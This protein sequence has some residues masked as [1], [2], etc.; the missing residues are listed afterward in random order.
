MYEE[1]MR[2]LDTGS[3]NTLHDCPDCG[4]HKLSVTKRD[5]KLLYHCW[6][7]SCGIRGTIEL[8]GREAFE[9]HTPDVK[10]E[11][12]YKGPINFLH[13]DEADIISTRFRLSA[14][15]VATY[16]RKNRDRYVLPIYT[17]DGMLRGYCLRWP[18]AGTELIQDVNYG[19]LKSAL[20]GEHTERGPLQS[21][22]KSTLGIARAVVLVEDQISAM[23]LAQDA[24]VDAVALLGVSLNAEK[25]AD[26]QRRGNNVVIALDADATRTAFEHARTWGAAF[27]SCRVT[28][29]TKDV[30][31][32]TPE[33]LHDAFF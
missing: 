31:D 30:K 1:Y 17:R 29:L 9:S 25:V 13:P 32:M 20:Y 2:S 21:W 10:E 4:H 23:R 14:Y 3:A 18:W 26:I 7:A 11:H 27:K 19:G 22:Y 24:S 5:G 6:R 12:R 33:E 15:T 28:V 16:I 8:T